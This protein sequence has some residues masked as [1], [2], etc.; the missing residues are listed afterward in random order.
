M[1]GEHLFNEKGIVVVILF[2]V[3]PRAI[4]TGVCL[5]KNTCA[6]LPGQG[7]NIQLQSKSFSLLW[8]HHEGGNEI[9]EEPRIATGIKSKWFQM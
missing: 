6:D 8:R 5:S 7:G 3:S 4:Q 9:F 2:S 1:I